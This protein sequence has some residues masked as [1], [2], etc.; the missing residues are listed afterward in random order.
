M[1][2]FYCHVSVCRLKKVIFRNLLNLLAL[3]DRGKYSQVQCFHSFNSSD[4]PLLSVWLY[5]PERKLILWRILPGNIFV[6]EGSQAKYCYH[7][8]LWTLFTN[9]GASYVFLTNA[10]HCFGRIRVSFTR[11]AIILKDDWIAVLLLLLCLIHL[12]VNIKISPTNT[13]SGNENIIR[14]REWTFK[15]HCD[16]VCGRP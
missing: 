5:F 13:P 2:Y 10:F 1:P 8:C 6:K 15:L 16:L 14:T 4:F 3:I 11:F 7:N 9:I 12:F